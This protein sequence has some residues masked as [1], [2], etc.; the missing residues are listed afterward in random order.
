MPDQ[1]LR[2]SVSLSKGLEDC[3]RNEQ[4]CICRQVPHVSEGQSAQR[5]SCQQ[6]KCVISYVGA[7]TGYQG[8]SKEIQAD[9][10]EHHSKRQGHYVGMHVAQDVAEQGKFLDRIIDSCA[11]SEK[12][13]TDSC[14]SPK[15]RHD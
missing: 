3:Q 8:R 7:H 1:G 11:I 15:Y 14:S 13:L 10:Q 2:L 5:Q 9:A 4:G 12:A 6:N